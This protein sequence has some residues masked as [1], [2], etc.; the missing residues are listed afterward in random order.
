MGERVLRGAGSVL[1]LYPPVLGC[2]KRREM[3]IQAKA[4]PNIAAIFPL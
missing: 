4:A 3:E 1:W 2:G